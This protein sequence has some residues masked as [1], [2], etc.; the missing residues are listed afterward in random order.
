MYSPPTPNAHPL[1]LVLSSAELVGLIF[2][3]GGISRFLIRNPG[4]V[5]YRLEKKWV[6]PTHIF[7]E[8]GMR[9]RGR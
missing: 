4:G 9:D 7:G 5:L 3:F 1:S 8:G 2:G 6:Q